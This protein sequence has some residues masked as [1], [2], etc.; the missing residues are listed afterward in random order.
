MNF[1]YVIFKN[2]V[3]ILCKTLHLSYKVYLIDAVKRNNQ[4][5]EIRMNSLVHSDGK[6]H[7]WSMCYMY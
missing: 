2:S 6:M 4:C 5:L 3:Y 1:D 7:C